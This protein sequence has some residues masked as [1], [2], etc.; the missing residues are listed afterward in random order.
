MSNSGENH[1][2]YVVIYTGYTSRILRADLA[3]IY[4]DCS[5]D[6]FYN[7]FDKKLRDK[8]GKEPPTTSKEILDLMKCVYIKDAL[9]G[10]NTNTKDF[11][12]EPDGIYPIASRAEVDQ[13]R[14]IVDQFYATSPKSH[15]SDGIIVFKDTDL[16]GAFKL[17]NFLIEVDYCACFSLRT[18][19]HVQMQKIN[20]MTVFFLGFDCESG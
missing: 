10:P 20:N 6:Y 8:N 19:Y 5:C 14:T 1:A 15:D 16:T 17:V 3:Q 9:W 12:I 13:A 4:V 2:D 18:L 11:K 7:P